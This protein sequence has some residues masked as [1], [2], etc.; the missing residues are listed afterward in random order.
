MRSGLSLKKGR[1]RA[2]TMANDKSDGH[3]FI[4]EPYPMTPEQR[5]AIYA[6]LKAEFSAADLQ[7]FT[8]ID[9]MIPMEVVLREIEEICRGTTK[10][11]S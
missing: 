9:E 10:R 5:A 1:S 3:D 2:L 6:K 8:E 4:P 11:E 7:R